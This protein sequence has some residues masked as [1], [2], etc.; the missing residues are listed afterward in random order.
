MIVR[1]PEITLEV[2]SRA[3]LWTLVRRGAIAATVVAALVGLA[4][5]QHGAGFD[6]RGLERL[7]A[8]TAADPATTG[9]VGR[10]GTR[11]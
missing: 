7:T 9:S 1:V 3:T 5:W 8:S 2:P 6:R 4:T 10:K 11:K